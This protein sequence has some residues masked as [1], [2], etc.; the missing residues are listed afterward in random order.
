ML[1]S[2]FQHYIDK[3]LEELEDW[4]ISHPED[5]EF[6]ETIRLKVEVLSNTKDILSFC[7]QIDLISYLRRDSGPLSGGFMPSFS[8]L[9]LALDM[10]QKRKGVK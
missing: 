9:A 10:W 6:C 8:E 5:S 7:R 2:R 1:T 4:R 3:T